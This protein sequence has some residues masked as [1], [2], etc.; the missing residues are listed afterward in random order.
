MGVAIPRLG[1][2]ASCILKQRHGE[3]FRGKILHCFCGF[4]IWLIYARWVFAQAA[5]V[6]S[7][8]GPGRAGQGSDQDKL[9][10]VSGWLLWERNCRQKAFVL[11]FWLFKMLSVAARSAPSLRVF[12]RSSVWPG[13]STLE[14]EKKSKCCEDFSL[15]PPKKEK[16]DL[17]GNLT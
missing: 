3:N 14:K 11:F 13:W 10:F 2:Q 8:G 9:G 5:S 12:F 17:T 7:R 16:R 15:Q 1:E 6:R 4:S